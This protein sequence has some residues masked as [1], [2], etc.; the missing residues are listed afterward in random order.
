MNDELEKLRGAATIEVGALEADDGAVDSTA[1][2]YGLD[3]LI[4]QYF[5]LAPASDMWLAIIEELASRPMS[6]APAGAAAETARRPRQ[7]RSVTVEAALG[8]P[9]RDARRYLQAS[10]GLGADAAEEFL[11]R[12]AASLA[13]QSPEGVRRLAELAQRPLG[14][15]FSDIASSWRASGNYVYAYR[16]GL[17]A[18]EPALA[19]SERDMA[20]LVDWGAALLA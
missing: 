2:P 16:P 9:L 8:V 1:E 7:A 17:T 11:E 15:L 13:T 20:A 6:D 18:E 12:P 10:L 3:D 14:E 4:E 5:L 19:A